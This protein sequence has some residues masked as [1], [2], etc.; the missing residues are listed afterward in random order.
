MKGL[1]AVAILAFLF[2]SCQK[3]AGEGGSSSISGKVSKEFR[4]DVTDPD[5]KTFTVAAADED[6]YIVYGDHTSPDDRVLT[7]Y[8]GEFSFR[9]LRPG[10]YEVYIYS[11][12]TTGFNG[13]DEKKMPISFDV[14]IIDK[15]QEVKLG[16]ITIYD[17]E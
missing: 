10:D 7:N 1:Y 4:V 8:D 2:M 11:R 14:E 9:N 13:V 12:D 3:P 6:V 5:T 15:D 16:D 17:E